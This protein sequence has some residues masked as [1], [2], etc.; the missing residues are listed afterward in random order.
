MS[1]GIYCKQL[2]GGRLSDQV[3][4]PTYPTNNISMWPSAWSAS[5][6]YQ[7]F[8]TQNGTWTNHHT[9]WRNAAVGRRNQ[10]K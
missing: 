2:D 7:I 3:T 1:Q 6:N 5:Q 9:Q 10:V 8:T 4:K